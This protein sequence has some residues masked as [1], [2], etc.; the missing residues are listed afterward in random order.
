MLLLIEIAVPRLPFDRKVEARLYARHGIGEYWVIDAE[1][2]VTWAHTGP[3][4]DGWS[5]IVGSGPDEKLTPAALPGLSYGIR[6]INS[7]PV[8]RFCSASLN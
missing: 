3:S 2:C 8:P 5:S 6:L 4:G 7:A 1:A